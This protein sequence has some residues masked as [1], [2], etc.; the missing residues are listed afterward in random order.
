MLEA[1]C[2]QCIVMILTE[3]SNSV[4]SSTT[5]RSG[6]F[7]P[8][9]DRRFD[10]RIDLN[11]RGGG[12]EI[13]NRAKVVR[14]RYSASAAVP[15]DLD[16]GAGMGALSGDIVSPELD[17]DDI[18]AILQLRSS[19]SSLQDAVRFGID[20]RELVRRVGPTRSKVDTRSLRDVYDIDD[21]TLIKKLSHNF[22]ASRVSL[23][24]ESVGDPTVLV[25]GRLWRVVKDQQAMAAQPIQSA[26]RLVSDAVRMQLRRI[27]Y[28]GPLRSP[29]ERFY[30]ASGG[31][32]DSVG[33]RGQDLM[34]VLSGEAVGE[35]AL[36]AEKVNRWF[37]QFEIPY[38]LSI[39][40]VSDVVA[41]EL[42]I[43]E[44]LDL[45]RQ[46]PVSPS[47]VGFGF[48]QLLPILV[49]G[50]L[51]SSYSR[52][53]SRLLCVEQPEIHLHPRL[54]AH[55]ADFMIDT[56]RGPAGGVQWVVETHSEA[57]LLRLQRRIR[58]GLIEADRVR[59]LYVDTDKD[60][61]AKVLPIRLDDEGDFVDDWPGGFF[62]EPMRERFA[63]R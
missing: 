53:L 61:N 31:G 54:Q 35:A 13:G 33:V 59:V 34:R 60:G 29:P 3:R 7:G 5:A 2:R 41:G 19:D 32:A 23:A 28:L 44:L 6:A 8:M 22:R 52:R 14:A 40:R 51:A 18:A 50:L 38:K 43:L 48:S 39:R 9:P 24:I 20:F 30:V 36:L 37:Q 15:F 16:F 55:V 45:V 10:A 49:E 46:V 4:C 42:S 47:D 56:S 21:L 26:L 11:F 63:S 1:S 25:D 62:E 57:L 12:N 27:H 58:E 17:E